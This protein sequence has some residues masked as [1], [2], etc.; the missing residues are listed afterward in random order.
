MSPPTETIT[1]ALIE[2][3]R[4]AVT[5]LILNRPD[6]R[7]ALSEGLLQDLDI[8]LAR[9]ADDHRIRIVVIAA[10]G[11]VFCS[12]HDLSEMVGRS[13]E[14]LLPAIFALFGRHDAF[15][16]LAAAGHC[17]RAGSGDRGRMSDGRR[18]RPR[19][20]GRDRRL[21]HTG[22]EDRAVLRDADG[23]AGAGHPGEA[24][25]G[26]AA[27]WQCDLSPPPGNWVWSIVWSHTRNSMAPS[28]ST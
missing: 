27:D 1:P 24:G 4:G 7:N 25:P 8:A 18:V 10:R 6:R 9:I 19:R 13:A 17:P 12:G 26:D 28:R 21:R 22:R 2:E 23:A 15:A 3:T 11:P 16:S 5:H 14:R 20:R